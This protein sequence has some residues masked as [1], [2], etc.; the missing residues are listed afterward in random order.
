MLLFCLFVLLHSKV[1]SG[2]ILNDTENK[3][4]VESFLLY[5]FLSLPML[6]VV[7]VL[8]LYCKMRII[9][10]K[11]QHLKL[12][13]P[14]SVQRFTALNKGTIESFDQLNLFWGDNPRVIV[15]I[16]QY[17]QF[18]Y[19]IGL[20]GVFVYFPKWGE[21]STGRFLVWKLHT[22]RNRSCFC[23]CLH[24][25]IFLSILGGFEAVQKGEFLGVLL[26]SYAIFSKVMSEIIP[27]YTLCTSMGQ[28]VN[29]EM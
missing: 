8:V 2:M 24:S 17:I 15:T 3:Q 16:I 28:L 1:I 21:S 25:L 14:K 10:Y 26:L 7:T 4:N 23:C 9:F 13:D 22:N 29:K 12:D 5:I 20:A 11:I 27:L 19:A 6:F 18:W